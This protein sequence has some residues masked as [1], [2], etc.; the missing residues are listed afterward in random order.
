MDEY[1]KIGKVVDMFGGN[2]QTYRNW[3]KDERFKTFFSEAAQFDEE[4]RA[5]FNSSD[6]L[7]IN[8]IWR[9]SRGRK[10]SHDE[11]AGLLA[12]GHRE[13]NFPD[14]AATVAASTTPAIQ[15]AGRALSAEDRLTLVLEQLAKAQELLIIVQREKEEVLREKGEKVEEL[16][17][18]IAD[19]KEEAGSLRREN[20]LFD[21]GRLKPSKKSNLN[22]T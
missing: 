6:L 11:I 9:L 10:H 20:E 13:T 19:L 18:M 12:N 22:T 14:R 21:Q 3:V 2:A 17:M 5:L 4:K 8:T 7:V 15:L 1:V 16:M